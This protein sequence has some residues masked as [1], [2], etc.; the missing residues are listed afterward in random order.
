MF[1]YVKYYCLSEFVP[2]DD[3]VF[4]KEKLCVNG[5]CRT[6][7]NQHKGVYTLYEHIDQHTP[8]QVSTLRG[9]INSHRRINLFQ[10]NVY[11]ILVVLIKQH[12]KIRFLN[13]LV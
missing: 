13:V 9:N 7:E 5:I 11:T 2:L 1:I 12:Y 3:N 6:Y 8:M 4:R 10:L